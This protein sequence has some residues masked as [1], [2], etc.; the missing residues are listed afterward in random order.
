MVDF[1]LLDDKGLGIVALM[2]FV[3]I[4]G[5]GIGDGLGMVDFVQLVVIRPTELCV[6][7]MSSSHLTFNTFSY[8]HIASFGDKAT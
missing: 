3:G 4:P 1:L 6:S 8:S 5:P 2:L 7:C